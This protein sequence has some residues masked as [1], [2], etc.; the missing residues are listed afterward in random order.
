MYALQNHN[1]RSFMVFLDSKSIPS[2]DYLFVINLILTFDWFT[3][4]T[5]RLVNRECFCEFSSS[6]IF[7]A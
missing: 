7:F 4:A 6:C 3:L 2:F 1:I 5:L